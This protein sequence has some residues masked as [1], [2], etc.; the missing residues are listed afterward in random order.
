MLRAMR[1]LF[2]TDGSRGASIAEDFLLSLPLSVADE[3]TIVTSPTVSER[4]SFALLSRCRWR[5]AARDVPTT[6]AL[7]TG[8]PADVAELVALERG[9]ELVVLGSRGLGQWSGTLL[10]SVSRTIARNGVMPVLVVRSRREAPRRALLAIDGSIDGRAAIDLLAHF[11]LPIAVPIDLLHVHSHDV[12]PRQDDAV[13]THARTVLGERLG[14]T[15]IVD[16]GHIGE[17]VLRRAL[18][19]NEDL[20]VLGVRGHTL[21]TGLLRTSIA[22]HVLS[23]A[24]CAVL[25]AKSPVRP[26]LIEAH[27]AIRASTVISTT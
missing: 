3:V 22:D 2:A 6:T 27:Q 18:T 13:M 20:I 25:V 1:F 10:G 5:F 8:S 19:A 24:H 23:H 17:E 4:E 21:G 11:P 9:A 26:R 15:E 16:R 7:R 14:G 12:E